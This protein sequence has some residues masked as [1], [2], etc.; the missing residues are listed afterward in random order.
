MA[1]KRIKIKYKNIFILLIVLL[2]ITFA[3]YAILNL[4]VKNIYVKNNNVLS[5]QQV[6]DVALLRDYPKVTSLNKKEIK[7]LLEDNVY[8]KSAKVKYKNFGQEIDIEVEEN[9]PLLYYLYDDT[10]LLSDSSSVKDEY[11]LPT[12]I[13]QTPDTIL[14]KLLKKID[15]LDD[16]A[17][18]RISEIRYYPSKVDEELFLL[19]MND[20][21]YVYINFN[22]FNKLNS[23]AD[24]LKSFDNKKGI[25]HLDSGNYLELF[26]T[27]K[28]N[29]KN[30]EEKKEDN[31][32]NIN[33]NSNE[34]N[35]NSN[36]NNSNSNEVNSN[37][38]NETEN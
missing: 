17:V 3:V 30:K 27:K 12:L 10:Y 22:S 25:L 32:S 29:D 36:N 35:S 31:K 8:I 34:V 7:K 13:N 18:G 19:I 2:L 23:Y 20:G 1:K 16:D 37:S 4:K 9:R 33:S 15:E 24:I 38:N 26:K 6:I 28:D 5:D 14:K 11:V 21:N